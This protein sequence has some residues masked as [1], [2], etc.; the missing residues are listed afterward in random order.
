MKKHALLVG[1]FALG[2][3]ALVVTTV[4]WLSGNSLFRKQ[5]LAVI[6]FQGGV[7]G[8][9]VGAPVTFRGVPV[10]QV[11]DIGIEVNDRSL[12]ARIPVRIRINPDSVRFGNA[13]G[14]AAAPPLPTLVQRGLRARL[15]AQSFVT[16]Q[17]L[18]D[19]DFVEEAPPPP[20][21]SGGRYPE[22]PA[23]RDRFDALFDQVAQL[24]LRETIEDVRSTL[25]TL[26]DTLAETRDTVVSARQALDAVAK[27]VNGLAGEGQRTL[28]AA[29][30][31]M[32]ELR[33]GAATSLANVNKLLEASRQTVDA[34]QPEL[35]ATLAGARAAAEAAQQAMSRVGE[36]A[37]PGAPLRGDLDAAVRDLSQAA[38][39]LRE[40]SELI[41]EQ[42]NAVI[43]GRRRQ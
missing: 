4:L 1:A 39:G 14:A 5:T 29:T 11:E 8:L 16:G 13:D 27:Q 32:E 6:H 9:Y 33:V 37:E 42:P 18:V 30:A 17:K 41:E 10:G 26:N 22:I 23:V 36:L 20:Q 35:Q 25:H 21:A 19:L 28:G 2:A 31:A 40:F 12:E 7:A 15:V 24:P 3:L 38:R 43:F 34:A